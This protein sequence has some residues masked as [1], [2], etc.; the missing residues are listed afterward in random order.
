MNDVDMKYRVFVTTDNAL[1]VLDGRTS[2]IYRDFTC[3]QDA[4][5]F[6]VLMVENAFR[7]ALFTLG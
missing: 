2:A 3:L 7:V 1:D 6:L 4:Y 5:E